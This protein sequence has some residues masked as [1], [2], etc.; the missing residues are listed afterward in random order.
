VQAVALAPDDYAC[1]KWV[2]ITLS[3]IGDYE[4]TKASIQNAYV[5]REYFDTALRLNPKV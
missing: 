4:G 1:H 5:V 2:A 3:S